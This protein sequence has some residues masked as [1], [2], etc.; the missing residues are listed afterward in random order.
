[1]KKE[2]LQQK[3]D[4]T[5]YW[6]AKILD[7]KIDYFGDEVKIIF[8]DEKDSIYELILSQCYKVYY[9]TDAERRNIKTVEEMNI[10]QLAYFVQDISI[11]DSD[12]TD[13]FEVKLDLFPLLANVVCKEI[14]VNKKNIDE[15]DFF[16]KEND[17]S[18]N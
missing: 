3:V 11:D 2:L 9:E 8:E 13:F 15:I 17:Q 16:W 6:D 7:F 14:V 10:R 1:M 4:E 18:K 12:K 5:E